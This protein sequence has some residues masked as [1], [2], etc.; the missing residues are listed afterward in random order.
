ME[1]EGVRGSLREFEGVRGVRGSSWE[2]IRM[3]TLTGTAMPSTA[4]LAREFAGVLGSSE[5]EVPLDCDTRCAA[6]VLGDSW[7][8]VGAFA[9]A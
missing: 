7:E 3:L 4:R 6:R 2:Y 8:F 1:F 5:P 9:D